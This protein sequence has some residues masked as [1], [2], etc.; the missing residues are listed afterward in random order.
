M[1]TTETIFETPDVVEV[2][3]TLAP[4]HEVAG[5]D[6]VSE[7]TS[8]TAAFEVFAGRGYSSYSARSSLRGTQ[9]DRRGT[10]EPSASI[11]ET[12]DPESPMDRLVRLQ[13]ECSSLQHDLMSLHQGEKAKDH[14]VI[15]ATSVWDAMA[16]AVKAL[17]QNL[18]HMSVEPQYKVNVAQLIQYMLALAHTLTLLHVGATRC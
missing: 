4:P 6:V 3:Q 7:S 16:Q 5:A 15:A 2:P 13:A 18:A 1:A 11:P 9:H 14:T 10:T 17:E 12:E 8:P